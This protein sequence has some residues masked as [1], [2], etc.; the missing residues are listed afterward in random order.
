MED[1][2]VQLN[3]K[4]NEVLNN[5][6][7]LYTTDWEVIKATELNV[8][9]DTSIKAVRAEARERINQLETE[10]ADLKEQIDNYI[11]AIEQHV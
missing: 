10:I 8:E 1:L 9:L 5:K 2:L 3:E 6:A 4:D 11:E 7:I